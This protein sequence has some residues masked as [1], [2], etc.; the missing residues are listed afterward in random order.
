MSPLRPSAGNHPTPLTSSVYRLC[1]R[2][3]VTLSSISTIPAAA[4][5]RPPTA[6]ASRSSSSARRRGSE[7]AKFRAVV[8]LDGMSEFLITYAQ[9]LNKE[10]VWTQKRCWRFL[11]RWLLLQR[12]FRLLH[13]RLIAALSLPRMEWSSSLV[14]I[15]MGR[16]SL[17]TVLTAPI[18]RIAP[19]AR[20]V[21]ILLRAI[22]QTRRLTIRRMLHLRT[23]ALFFVRVE[24]EQ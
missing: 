14:I 3:R 24:Y 18:A 13:L 20:T 2:P 16:M 22:D 6:A 8:Q 15:A 1:R 5:A 19:I 12:L 21:R 23:C 7:F 10:E 9:Q 4:T 11:A 17:G